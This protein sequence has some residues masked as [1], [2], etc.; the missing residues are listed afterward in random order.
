MS[1]LI[2]K[3]WGGA[4]DA[5]FLTSAQGMLMLCSLEHTLSRVGLAGIILFPNKLNKL[6]GE[7]AH[8]AG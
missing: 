4:R 5:V 6:A 8:P 3:I 7:T 2:Q 1:I